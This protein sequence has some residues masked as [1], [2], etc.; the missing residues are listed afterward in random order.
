MG[1]VGER[2]GGGTFV[3][4]VDDVAGVVFALGVGEDAEVLVEAVALEGEEV[5][6]VEG[7]D[8]DGVDAG[9]EEAKLVGDGKALDCVLIWELPGMSVRLG[10]VVEVHEGLGLGE[11]HY[12]RHCCRV[13]SLENHRECKTTNSRRYLMFARDKGVSTKKW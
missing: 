7:E 8:V 2:G 12:C 11:G 5:E 10:R 6:E 9:E 3:V 1:G 13:V 4:H